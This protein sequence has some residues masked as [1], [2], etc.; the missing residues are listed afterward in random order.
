MK[1]TMIL[2]CMTIMCFGC[3]HLNQFFGLED[4]NMIEE[5]IED[6]IKHHTGLDIDLTPDSEEKKKD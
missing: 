6:V 2:M 5:A 4:D 1:F 3:S